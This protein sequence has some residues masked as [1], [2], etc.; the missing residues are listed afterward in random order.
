M[1]RY[2]RT[3]WI[4]AKEVLVM[5]GETGEPGTVVAL[6]PRIERSFCERLLRCN[7]MPNDD[8]CTFRV[9]L[10]YEGRDPRSIPQQW[11]AGARYA[12]VLD[13]GTLLPVLVRSIDAQQCRCE[14][15]IEIADHNARHRVR[16]RPMGGFSNIQTFRIST[17]ASSPHHVRNCFAYASSDPRPTA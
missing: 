14:L 7:V 4:G 9:D 3:G 2:T 15:L 6:G 11:F 1:R 12:F 8:G 17:G 10:P 13:D 5:A 16:V